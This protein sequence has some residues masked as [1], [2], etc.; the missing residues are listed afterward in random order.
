MQKRTL[1]IIIDNLTKGGAELMLVGILP[2]L[3]KNYKVILVTL[4]P[5]CDFKKEEIF[6]SQKYTL[7]FKSKLSFI[8]SVYKL[9]KII[10]RYQPS[11]IH[12]HLIYS[13]LAA[14]LACPGKI[15]LLYSVHG[16]LSKSDF[17]RSWLLTIIEKTSIRKNHFV[18]AVS[19]VALNDYL[20]T[21][22]KT[23][24]TFVLKNYI[25]DL[26]FEKNLK[27]KTFNQLQPLKII[28][29]GN[30]KRAKNYNYLLQSFLLLK[31]FDVS[32]DIFGNTDHSLYTE[33]QSL[34]D[35]NQLSVIFKGPADNMHEIYSNYDA[36]VMSST[37]EG[38]GIA[39]VEAMACGL[40]VMLSDI[41]VFREAT[42]NNA[43][44]FDLNDP[45]ALANLI[46]QIIQGKFN[47]KE[48]SEK[49]IE[50]SRGYTKQK[51]LKKL[52]SIYEEVL[53]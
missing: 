6:C 28:A 4:S 30:L 1:L 53:Q 5:E 24:K 25:A 46:K 10:R 11:L 35:R 8:S 23:K 20:K 37:N 47:L 45:L 44:F 19:N 52:F 13:S 27:G 9:K 33:L 26:F 49:G 42:F 22:K 18:M 40:P 15:P 31:E 32:L 14:R 16:E 2:E 29:V 21:I 51:Y 48:I 39:A 36:F 34:I 41:P 17:N 50:I 43:L 3:N 38:F 7:D 12:S